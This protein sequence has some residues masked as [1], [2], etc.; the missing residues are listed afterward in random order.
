VCEGFL[1]LKGRIPGLTH[2][3]IGLDT[4]RVDYACDVVLY[5][6]FESL[7]ALQA[8]ATHPA[9]L[10]VRDALQGIRIDRYQ[11]DYEPAGTVAA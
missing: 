5:S 3:E 11:V 2:L 1:G 10:A 4:S 6:E 7:D 8:Y 9:H